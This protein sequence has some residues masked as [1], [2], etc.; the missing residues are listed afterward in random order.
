MNRLNREGS[1]DAKK[2]AK[3]Y[4]FTCRSDFRQVKK[5]MISWRT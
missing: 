5:Q 2:N 3:I 1:K 4:F